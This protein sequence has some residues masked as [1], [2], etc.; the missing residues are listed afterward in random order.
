MEDHTHSTAKSAAAPLDA[1]SAVAWFRHAAQLARRG[2]FLDAEMLIRSML[3][4]PSGMEPRLFDL[5]ARIYAQQ[6]R[7]LDAESCWQTAIKLSPGT[8]QYQDAL[9]TL[10]RLS[11]PQ[12]WVSP[13]R[14]LFNA[15]LLISCSYLGILLYSVVHQQASNN[16]TLT[17]AAAEAPAAGS[18]ETEL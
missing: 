14:I 1:S 11:R 10:Q 16:G 18:S 13:W 7:A 3:R 12:T 17:G 4:Q 15:L 9:R 2:R 5:L 8:T 6:G